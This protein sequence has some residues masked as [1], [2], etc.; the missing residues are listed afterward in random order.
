MRGSEPEPVCR[1]RTEAIS[2]DG[3]R[4]PTDRL[5]REHLAAQLR[6][7][8]G[9]WPRW[10]FVAARPSSPG[11]RPAPDRCTPPTTPVGWADT[12]AL[13]VGLAPELGAVLDRTD[14]L[15]RFDAGNGGAYW[16]PRSRSPPWPAGPDELLVAR[17]ARDLGLVRRRGCPRPVRS[18]R[19]RR[20]GSGS[21]RR[22]KLYRR[23]HR[24]RLATTR[25][26]RRCPAQPRP[27]ASRSPD[28]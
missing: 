1:R 12:A 22:T 26:H 15:G 28:P 6:L 8:P 5:A 14:P 7:L 9:H 23:D 17:S 4:S 18:R 24:R 11:C 10:Q 13:P 2:A 3:P 20:R 25:P 19:R 16:V 21:A 27:R